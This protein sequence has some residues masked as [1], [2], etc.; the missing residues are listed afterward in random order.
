MESV[1]AGEALLF[2][3]DDEDEAVLLGNTG[4]GVEG[5]RLLSEMVVVFLLLFLDFSEAY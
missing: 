3:E 2:L 1:E 5:A 4:V